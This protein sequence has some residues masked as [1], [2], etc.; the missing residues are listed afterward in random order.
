[1]TTVYLRQT[2][3]GWR[4]Y[5]PKGNELSDRSF[6]GSINAAMAWAN[7][8]MSYAPNVFVRLDM[9]GKETK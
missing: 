2:A 3:T 6:V 9:Q 1:M 7:A 8:Y 5:G 4:I